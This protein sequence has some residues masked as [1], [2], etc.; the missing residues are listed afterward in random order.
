MPIAM[1]TGH[2]VDA[3]AASSGASCHITPSAVTC[4]GSQG[5][6]PGESITITLTGTVS[7]DVPVK[8][9]ATVTGND[10]DPDPDDNIGQAELTPTDNPPDGS[11]DPGDQGDDPPPVIDPDPL[12]DHPVDDLLSTPL[13]KTAH[14]GGSVTHSPGRPIGLTALAAAVLLAGAAMVV[15][16]ARRMPSD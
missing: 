12:D 1:I 14:T 7:G 3:T 5:L 8:N 9:V 15:V 10:K 11:D 16:V 4:A 6:K 13:T 2:A